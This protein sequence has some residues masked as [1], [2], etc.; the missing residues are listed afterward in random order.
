M[1]RD[2]SR[3]VDEFVGWALPTVFCRAE[4]DGGKCPLYLILIEHGNGY[5]SWRG[6][7]RGKI[8]HRHI[9]QLAHHR[10][11]IA[12]IALRTAHAIRPHLQR[13]RIFLHDHEAE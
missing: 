13:Q 3:Y 4:E 11:L 5:A 7:G 6:W 9:R 1:V 8:G 12:S 10:D 2:D